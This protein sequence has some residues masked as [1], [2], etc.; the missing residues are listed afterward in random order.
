VTVALNHTIVWCRDKEVS[1]RYLC[2]VL[3]L[4]VPTPFGPFLVVALA[5]GVSM[6]FRNHLGTE[7]DIAPQHYA[8]LVSDAEFE[9][10]FGRIR[11]KGQEYWADPQMSSPG[12][13]NER[14][15]GR[16]VYFSDPDGHMLEIITVPYGGAG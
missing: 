12:E 4:G 11:A 14:D 15:G 8:F 1:A 13:V 6:D 5:N 3:G 7:L 16:G 9:E 2:D 10:I